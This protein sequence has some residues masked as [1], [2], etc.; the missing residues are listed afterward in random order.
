MVR[1]L[2]AF[3]H[4]NQSARLYKAPHHPSNERDS[5]LGLHKFTIFQYNLPVSD[6]PDPLPQ[7][8]PKLQNVSSF[9]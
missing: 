2:S 9:K 7:P 6:C 5:I 4:D 1:G 8:N 3:R